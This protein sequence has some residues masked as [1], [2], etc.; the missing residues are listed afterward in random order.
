MAEDRTRA[1]KRLVIVAAVVLM[2]VITA[3]GVLQLLPADDPAETAAPPVHYSAT[4]A[5]DH[6]LDAFGSR[7]AAAAGA[8]TDDPAAATAQLDEVFRGLRPTAVVATRTD[9]AE[10]AAGAHTADEPFTLSWDLGA[11]R[12]WEYP[13]AL[14]VVEKDAGWVVDWQPGLVHPRLTAGHGLVM[15]DLAGKPAVRDRAGAPLL[16]WAADEPKAADPKLAPVL[17][18]GM[19]RVAGGRTD[20]A[21]WYVALVDAAGKEVAV[22]HGTRPKPLTATLSRPV[23]QAAQRAV[24]STP[25]AAM[26]VAVQPSTGDLLAVAQ[27]TAA[28]PAPVALSGQFPPGSTFKIATA[29]AILEAGRTGIDT[30]VPCPGVA[31]VGR[32]TV[33][34]A[35]F[36]L[37][38]VPLRTAFAQSCNTTFA[39]QAAGLAPD[40]LARA[41]S[42][43]GLAADF[44]IPGI[45]TETGDVPRSAD[46]TQQ[47]ESSIGQGR[48]QVSCFGMA[49]VAATVAAGHATT[50][51]LW[52]DLRT[53]VRSGYQA[54]PSS[55]VGGLRTMMRDVVTSGR[56]TALARYGDVHGKTGTAQVGDGTQ[57]HGWF[58]GYRGDLAFATL[59]LDSGASSA[60]VTVTGTFLG[61][62]SSR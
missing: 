31:T 9:L 27:N 62:V 54:P 8:L 58:A 44:D 45:T 23:Q 40:A 46:T 21:A 39:V 17:L 50:P 6:F 26:I 32:R 37:G 7:D 3:L 35:N 47:V 22:L 51:R 59:V 28:G 24:D 13:S 52:R 43:L 57:A 55:V 10:P 1:R 30:V 15:G 38:D 29:T 2:V 20:A 41:A 61:A 42:R 11:G 33:R 56:G 48:V 18:G 25:Y 16:T 34:N 49:L 5:A 36:E 14:R 19:A 4:E 12:G 53:T 60:A